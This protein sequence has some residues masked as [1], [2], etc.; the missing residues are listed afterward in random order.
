VAIAEAV[1]AWDLVARPD[2]GALVTGRFK[3]NQNLSLAYVQWLSDFGISVQSFP[4]PASDSLT[5]NSIWPNSDGGMTIAG[6]F[7]QAGDE[8]PY[9]IRLNSNGA[10]IWDFRLDDVPNDVDTIAFHE[11]ALAGDGNF[12]V[13]GSEN[14]MR[15]PAANRFF[16]QKFSPS[17]QFLW[18]KDFATH[19]SVLEYAGFDRSKILATPDGGVVVLYETYFDGPGEGGEDFNLTK[20]DASGNILWSRRFGRE[21]RFV[22][23]PFDLCHTSNGFAVASWFN[24]K[25]FNSNDGYLVRTDEQGLIFSNYVDGRVIFDE[26][27]DCAADSTE[28]KLAGW[29]IQAV[30]QGE[31]VYNVLTGFDGKFAIPTDTGQIILKLIPPNPAWDACQITQIINFT[32]PFDSVS[33]DFL[34]QSAT[35]CGVVE[36]DISTLFLRRCFESNYT[37]TFANRGTIL[38]PN[39]NLELNLDADLTFLGADF[40]VASQNGQTVNFDLGDLE[41]GEFGQIH[42]RVLVGC[43]SVALGQSHCSSVKITPQPVCLPSASWTGAHIEVEGICTNDTIFFNVKNTGIGPTGDPVGYIIVEEELLLKVGSIPSLPVGGDMIIP[44]AADGKT[45]RIQA[46][47]EPLDPYAPSDPS[48]AIAGC[49]LDTTGSFSTD[50]VTIF[51]NDDGDLTA[52][53]DCRINQGSFD[54]NRKDGFPTGYGEGR[55]IFPTTEIEYIIQFQNTGTDT[56]FSVIIRD[57]LSEFLDITTVRAGASSHSYLFEMSAANALK[58]TLNPIELPDSNT[59]EAASKG[60]VSFKV[61]PKIDLPLPTAIFNRA[62]IYFDFNEPIFTNKTLHRVD[63]GFIL[64]KPVDVVE[65]NHSVSEVKIEPNPSNDFSKISIKNWGENSGFEYKIRSL[66]G[67]E[68]LK[69]RVTES[70]FFIEKNKIGAGIFVI[71]IYR[72]GQIVEIGRLIFI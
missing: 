32:Q 48:V 12:W 13:V 68:L 1:K 2:G 9:L 39:A 15:G 41:I 42:V 27:M 19:L 16:I 30:R 20:L 50:Y 17:G 36:A 21:Q 66:D 56:A 55:F 51:P 3:I 44:V 33:V 7:R 23:S 45:Y 40:P 47:R 10:K 43:D 25:L 49:N 65:Q 57:T 6:Y 62:A 69:N 53:T 60:F 34:A 18:E 28:K 14:I 26:N 31:L 58:F 4:I 71:E 52:D 38:I 22:E 29:Q 35:D 46:E 63:T 11:V 37:L 54:P 70:S 8:D 64:K 67:R 5:L 59:N 61:R 24:D 72:N